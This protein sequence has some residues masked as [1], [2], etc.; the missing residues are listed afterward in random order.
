MNRKSRLLGTAF[1]LGIAAGVRADGEVGSEF[2]DFK[3]KD[4]ITGKSFSLKELRGYVVLVDYWAT[5]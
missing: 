4:A 5:W 3:A 2:P 1:L